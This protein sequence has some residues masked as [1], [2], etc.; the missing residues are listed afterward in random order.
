MLA[1]CDDPDHEALSGSTCCKTCD[2]PKG[3]TKRAACLDTDTEVFFG[4][5]VA[6]RVARSICARCQVRPYCAEAGWFEE[7]GVWA[8]LTDSQRHRISKAVGMW[9]L[10]TREQRITIRTLAA[11]PVGQ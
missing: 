6:T 3:W 8:G 7:H 11:R 10:S 4:G 2:A 1:D 5:A 9:S